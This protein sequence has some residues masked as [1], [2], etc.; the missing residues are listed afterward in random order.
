MFAFSFLLYALFVGTVVYVN[1]TLRAALADYAM[2]INAMVQV[3]AIDVTRLTRRFAILLFWV[4]TFYLGLWTFAVTLGNHWFLFAVCLVG[5]LPA[6]VCM[7]A[8]YVLRLPVAEA[9]RI[10]R[11]NGR[12][13]WDS[14]PAVVKLPNSLDP[15]DATGFFNAMARLAGM[16]P[17]ALAN[18]VWLL[19]AFPLKAAAGGIYLMGQAAEVAADVMRRIAG[20]LALVTLWLLF[21]AIMSLVDMMYGTQFT[22]PIVVA[23][24]TLGLMVVVCLW[25]LRAHV[26]M[27]AWLLSIGSV[28][29]LLAIMVSYFGVTPLTAWEWFTSISPAL[30]K[31]L[32]ASLLL[33]AWA[34]KKT[35]AHGHAGEGSKLSPGKLVVAGAV[36]LAIWTLYYPGASSDEWMPQG[37]AKKEVVIAT[38]Q[39]AGIQSNEFQLNFRAMNDGFNRARHVNTTTYTTTV[40]NAAL[41]GNEIRAGYRVAMD[42]LDGKNVGQ[43]PLMVEAALNSWQG[44]LPSL[45]LDGCVYVEAKGEATSQDGGE[46][47]SGPDGV[48]QSGLPTP[49]QR[50]PLA[51]PGFPYLALVGEVCQAGTCS[52]PFLVGSQRNMDSHVLGRG[53]V[54][55]RVN[56]LAASSFYGDNQG[57]YKISY[58]PAPPAACQ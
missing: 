44:M 52:A 21:W 11:E 53:E 5:A 46:V 45:Q 42:V 32:I 40:L 20:T 24:L 18:G 6:F 31:A 28:A 4:V 15:A 27:T 39:A 48:Y 1:P 43:P 41:E 33:V 38:K 16:T 25:V 50:F 51:A 7:Y 3:A 2:T 55:F 10:L 37:P 35:Y 13:L 56:D 23:L 34:M 12:W 29:G 9:G 57:G 14:V 49:L 17:F 19:A 30:A 26:P 22:H 58:R 47:H 36:L 54:K 8:V